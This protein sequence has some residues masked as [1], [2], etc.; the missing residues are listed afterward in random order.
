MPQEP[1]HHPVSECLWRQYSLKDKGMDLGVDV[2]C[3][4]RCLWVLKRDLLFLAFMG[5]VMWIERVWLRHIEV[6]YKWQSP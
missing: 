4:S 6:A 5:V 3:G 2:V 1:L